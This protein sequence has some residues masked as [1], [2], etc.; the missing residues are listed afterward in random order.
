M[1]R[2]S[3]FRITLLTAPSHP[4]LPEKWHHAVFVP[5]HSGGSTTDF[6]RFPFKPFLPT[7]LRKQGATQ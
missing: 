7:H 1:G 4:D 3:G 2:S 6:H 5:D